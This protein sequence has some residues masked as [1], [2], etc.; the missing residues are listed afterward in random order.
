MHIIYDTTQ[1]T[2]PE[3]DSNPQPEDLCHPL[4]KNGHAPLLVE[5]EPMAFMQNQVG[6]VITGSIMHTLN[7]NSNAT[8]RNAPNVIQPIVLDDQGGQVMNV[9]QDGKVGTLR[10]QSH[11]HEPIVLDKV[12]VRRLTPKECGRLQG[13]PDGYLEQVPGYSDSKAYSAFGNSMTVQVWIGGRID[14]VD[15]LMKEI[16]AKKTEFPNDK[17]S[18]ATGAK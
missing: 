7:K 16:E 10:A 12:L 2:S 1:V 14:K 4:V 17:R 3:N 11:Q 9:S 13:F 8:G 6:D 5:V 15:R 18:V